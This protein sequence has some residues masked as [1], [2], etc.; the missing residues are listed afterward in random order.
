MLI[1]AYGSVSTNSNVL[2]LEDNKLGNISAFYTD[3]EAYGL[4]Q[5]HTT[6][7]KGDYILAYRVDDIGQPKNLQ[8]SQDLST[9][10]LNLLNNTNTE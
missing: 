4:G 6:S 8:G 2:G 1:Y 7:S 9:E 10:N 3:D 5:H